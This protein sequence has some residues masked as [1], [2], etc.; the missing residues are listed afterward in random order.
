MW[1]H[2]YLA[3]TLSDALG[4]LNQHPDDSMVISG[5]TDLVLELKRGQHNDRTR[6]V[7]ISR[8][9]GLDKI[10]TDNIGALHIGALVTHNQ[11]TSSEMIRSNA[12]CLAEASFQV[13][14]PQIR[15]RGTVAGNLITA[16]P[17]NDTIPALIVL[18][19]E[20]VIVSPNGERRVKLED[21]YLGVRKTI[22]RKNE[23][24]KEIVLNPEAG[25]YHSTF[26]KFAL[27][28]AQAISVANAAVALKTYKGKVVG[29]RIA[30]GA[31][32][33]TVVRL[34]SIESQVSGLSLEQLENFQLPETIHEISPIS[35]IRGSAT[36][37]RE[38]IRVIVKRCIDTLL[39]PEKAGQKIPEN[40]IT[41]SDFEKHPHKGELKYSIAIDN[42]FPIHTT[43]NNQEYTFRNAHQKTLLDLIRENAR[44]TGSKEG[45]AEGEC[46]TCTVYLDGKAVMACLVPA[47][48]AHL[49]EIT[50]IE[51]IAQ[52]NQLHPVQQAFIE[53][54]AV[55]CGYCTPGFIMSAVKLLEERPHPSESEIKEGLTG[56]LCRCTGYYKII[57]AI[58]KASSS[59]GDHA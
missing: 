23:I 48:R 28:N 42:E 21:F 38:M 29:A 30:V 34:Q 43:I 44:L 50:T 16:S 10:Y 5:G 8:I 4:Y 36:F 12:R 3:A 58:E 37:R 59:G 20:L 49:A 39:Y 7:D 19:A 2:Y 24:L 25:I 14:S 22:L 51:G 1:N 41:L 18:G 35:D 11:V 13:G 54:G 9:S 32:A 56:N 52:E 33:P 40:P 47:P 46:G 15:N 31:V 26:Y 55:Q 53:E 6:I 45:C 27:R 57:K 17:A